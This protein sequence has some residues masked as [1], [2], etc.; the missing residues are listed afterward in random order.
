MITG[1]YIPLL[2]RTVWCLRRG[3]YGNKIEAWLDKKIGLFETTGIDDMEGEIKSV[4]YDCFPNPASDE[5]NF[6][7]F[8][9]HSSDVRLSLFDL[10][11]KRVAEILNG[12]WFYGEN[13][14]PYNISWLPAGMYL[15][16]IETREFSA[17]KKLVVRSKF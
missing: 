13:T 16:S 7:F 17:S 9:N 2:H 3:S 14:I 15:Y 4:L 1:R 12:H 5:V 8:I 11:N 6:S 10:N